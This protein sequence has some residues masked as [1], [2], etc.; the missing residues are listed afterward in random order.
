[1]W[2]VSGAGAALQEGFQPGFELLRRALRKVTL[3]M[4][5]LIL[6]LYLCRVWHPGELLGLAMGCGG[7]SVGGAGGTL[8]SAQ[9]G[10]GLDSCWH[11]WDR[12]VLSSGHYIPLGHL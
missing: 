1:M 8:H 3:G 9:A 10:G 11:R 4:T 5:P 6:H 7:S 2:D 12:A